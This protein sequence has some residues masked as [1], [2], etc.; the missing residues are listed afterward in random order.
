[1]SMKKVILVI[2]TLMFLTALSTLGAAVRLDIK[3][4]VY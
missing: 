4:R 1:M 3:L 2:F